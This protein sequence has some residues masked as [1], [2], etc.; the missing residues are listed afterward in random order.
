M[1]EGNYVVLSTEWWGD[2]RS[3][4]P[5]EASTLGVNW[6]YFYS[7]NQNI[8]Y[9]A[10]VTGSGT[11]FYDH[12]RGEWVNAIGIPLWDTVSYYNFAKA[13]VS[14]MQNY[15]SELGQRIETY[16]AKATSVERNDAPTSMMHISI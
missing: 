3:A 15:V 12:F 16:A 10:N 11:P 8:T 14:L 2:L 6:P 7:L 1:E 9:L 4:M 5:G 13:Y